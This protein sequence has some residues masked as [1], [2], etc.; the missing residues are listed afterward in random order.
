MR[1]IIYSFI[2]D[3]A[4]IFAYQGHILASSIIETCRANPSDIYIHCSAGVNEYIREIFLSLGINVIDFEPFGDGKYCNKLV[5]IPA[6]ANVDF[7]I[8]V[9]LDTDTVFVEDMSKEFST[10]AVSGKIVDAYNPSLEC[11]TS[12]FK[13]ADI[14]VPPIVPVDTGEGLTFAGNFNGGCYVIPKKFASELGQEWR[15]WAQFLLSD[16][17]HL[18]N[19]GKTAH[20]DQVSFAMACAN[21]D[22]PIRHMSTNHNYFT[23]FEAQKAYFDPKSHICMLHYHND[24][25]NVLGL[26]EK[27]RVS[28][29]AAIVAIDKANSIISR[30]FNNELFWSFRY[31][32]FPERGSGIGSRDENAQYKS[33]LLVEHGIENAS[34]ILDVGCGDLEVIKRLKLQG[35]LGLDSS[36]KALEIAQTKRPDLAFRLSQ[37][38][39]WP[40]KE[41]VVC[42]EVAIHQSTSKD[43]DELLKNVIA[44]TT[45]TLIISG[46]QTKLPHHMVYFY[47]PI[48][49]TLRRLGHFKS[50]EKIGAHTDVVIYRCDI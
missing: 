20:V 50:I 23:H 36:P 1:K 42:F 46:Y 10:D 45:K 5:Q 21:L 30:C 34:S 31:D 44:A 2:V 40:S 27:S 28:N 7:D 43:Y 12:I 35:Y 3:S 19:E 13:D 6:L 25:L 22:L 37:G 14:K 24:G 38:A 41:F 16:N 48:I 26:I 39:A 15:K 32:R 29:Q 11:L 8:L 47:E 33:E 49:E 9:L 18:A 4:P 17:R